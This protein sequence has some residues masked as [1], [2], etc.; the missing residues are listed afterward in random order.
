MTRPIGTSSSTP[1]KAI[2]STNTA[3]FVVKADRKTLPLGLASG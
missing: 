1:A 2:S 3:V